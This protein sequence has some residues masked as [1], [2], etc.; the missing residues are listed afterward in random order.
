LDL[1]PWIAD[2]AAYLAR[3]GYVAYA[4]D[5]RLKHL[6]YLNRFIEVRG[7]PTLEHF[8][9]EWASDFIDY[10]MRHHAGANKKVAGFQYQSRFEPHHHRDVQFSLRCFF[11]WAH[12]A[13]RLQHNPF[14]LRPL[15]TGRY[16]FPEMMDYLVFCEEHKGLARNTCKQIERLVRCFDQFLHAAGVTAWNQLQ[17]AHIDAFVRREADHNVR[18]IQNTHALLSGLLRY[19]FSLGRLDRDWACTLRSPRRYQLART[20][21]ALAADQVLHLLR[22][23]DR[24]RRGGKRDL[25]IILMAA[26]LGVRVSEIAALRLEQLDWT[27]AV[28]SFPA[29]KNQDVLPLPISRPLI[30]ALADYLKNERPKGSPYRNVFLALTPPLEPLASTSVSTIISRRMQRAGIRRSGHGLRHAFASELLR[31]G[32]SFP[33]LQQLLGHSHFSSTLVYTKIDLIQL[34]D[35]ANNDAEEL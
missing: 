20:P 5:R 23:I 30:E 9:P 35:V 25:A 1:T 28:V 10:W 24:S 3:N 6:D 13:G 18:R 7:L 14:P 15:L 19:L 8:P 26:S 2:Y 12:A 22:S 16:V 17:S 21:R 31:A 27:R 34:R 11:R 29:I 33:T 4:I 32:V